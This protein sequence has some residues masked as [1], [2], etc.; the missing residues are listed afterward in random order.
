MTPFSPVFSSDN[1]IFRIFFSFFFLSIYL[2]SS[3]SLFLFF[4]F[5]LCPAKIMLYG[6]APNYFRLFL[7]RASPKKLV[8]SACFGKE[9]FQRGKKIVLLSYVSKKDS[10]VYRREEPVG[11][12]RT[13]AGGAEW[14]SRFRRAAACVG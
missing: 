9:K 13:G 5:S 11:R 3:F 4:F 1:R 12:G 14:R 6:K 10:A 7:N 8:G 2:S